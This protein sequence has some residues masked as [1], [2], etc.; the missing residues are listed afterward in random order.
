[1]YLCF[2]GMCIAFIKFLM[3]PPPKKVK[4]HPTILLI[5][6]HQGIFLALSLIA[7]AP[8]TQQIIISIFLFELVNKLSFNISSVI[9]KLFYRKHYLPILHFHWE[10][11]AQGLNCSRRIRFEVKWEFPGCFVKFWNKILNE[12]VSFLHESIKHWMDTV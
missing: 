10:K 11:E 1:M 12:G 2:S 7:Q 5:S 4:N 6:W 3:T 8:W 9:F